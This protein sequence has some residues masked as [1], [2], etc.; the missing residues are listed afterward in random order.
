MNIQSMFNIF[1]KKGSILHTLPESMGVHDPRMTRTVSRPP[2]KLKSSSPWGATDEKR[3][4]GGVICNKSYTT[5]PQIRSVYLDAN[6]ATDT[7][8]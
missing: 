4:G 8:G 6:S 5:V 3:G 7:H 1:G 2:K